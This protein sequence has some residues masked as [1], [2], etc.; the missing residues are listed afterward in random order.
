MFRAYSVQLDPYGNASL[1]IQ[2]NNRAV[3][4]DIYQV[5]IRTNI[6]NPQCYAEIW[7]AGFFRCA[8]PQ[9]SMDTATGPPDMVCSPNETI[10]IRWFAGQPGDNATASIWYNENPSGTTV[11]YSH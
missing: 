8:S 4:W 7:H 11:S 6:F 10:Q 2:P 1:D 9:G 5:S 3:E